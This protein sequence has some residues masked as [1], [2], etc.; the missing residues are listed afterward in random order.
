MNTFRFSEEQREIWVNEKYNG[1]KSVKKICREAGI[2][3]ATLYNWMKDF[4]Q[5]EGM[6][7]DGV[8]EMIVTPESLKSFSKYDASSKYEMIT[9]ALS[10]VDPK[11]DLKRKLVRSIVKRF[12]LTVTQACA[13]VGLDEEL[14][15]YKPRKPEVDDTLVYDELTRLINEDLTRGFIQC[16]EIV[17]RTHPEWTRKQLKRVYR[18]Y[19]LYLKRSRVRREKIEQIT[20]RPN[21]LVR[22]E[23]NWSLGMLQG[24]GLSNENNNDAYWIM[25]IRD[26]TDS[27]WLNA[28]V[29]K[30]LLTEEDVIYF[31]TLAVVQNGKP[32]KLKVAGMPPFNTREMT[33]WM[34]EY[35][36]GVT[37]LSL[38]KPENTAQF[39]ELNQSFLTSF[40]ELGQA[41]GL[42][43]LSEIVNELMA[44][45]AAVK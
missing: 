24:S 28:S 42:D 6:D 43:N 27:A 22:P 37:M 44:R 5:P 30:G 20:E 9:A 23:A 33:K 35:K 25:F 7:K 36:V 39:N 3:R 19:R 29:G 4:P 15:G 16:Y 21:R 2:S 18:D 34:L 45:G 38:G 10:Q 40:P 11:G 41:T 14:Y 32:R 13:I 8:E 1:S 17:Q 26:D 12:T 31:L